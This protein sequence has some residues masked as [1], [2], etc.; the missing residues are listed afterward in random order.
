MTTEYI[1]V[2]ITAPNE[3]E[4]AKISRTL[5]GERLAACVNIIRSVR[6][7]YRWQGRVEDEQEVLMIAKTKRDLFKRLQERVKE[8]HSYKVPEIIGLPVIEGSKE[9]LDWLG[10]ETAT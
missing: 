7:I 9:Y 8:L 6:S 4:A 5:V 2:F 10:Q 3:E 1:T